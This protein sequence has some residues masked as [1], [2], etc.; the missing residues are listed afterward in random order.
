L[1]PLHTRL[2]LCAPGA[3]RAHLSLQADLSLDTL[4][5]RGTNFSLEPLCTRLSLF[6]PGAGRAHLPL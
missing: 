2:S 6:S 3:G 1:K 5:T 4:R